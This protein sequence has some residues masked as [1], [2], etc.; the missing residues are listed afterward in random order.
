MDEKS[1]SH[2]L[3]FFGSQIFIENKTLVKFGYVHMECTTGAADHQ[4]FD[5]HAEYKMFW[6]FAN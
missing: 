5:H 1:D 4:L 3:I 6:G 2:T